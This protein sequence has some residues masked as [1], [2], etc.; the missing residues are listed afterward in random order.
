MTSTARVISASAG[1]LCAAAPLLAHYPVMRLDQIR[2]KADLIFI[3]QVD[4]QQVRWWNGEKMQFTD[5]TFTGVEVLYAAPGVQ[6]PADG[7]IR[8]T[9]AGGNQIR[10]CCVPQFTAGDRLLI[11][12]HYDGKTYASAVVGG[13]QGAF[14]IERDAVT[15]AEHVLTFSGAAI[16]GFADG[17][18]VLSRKP[19]RIA[20][21]SGEYAE[22]HSGRLDSAPVALHTA[23]GGEVADAQTRRLAEERMAKP[24]MKLQ[25][26]T[27]LLVEGDTVEAGPLQTHPGHRH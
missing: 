19:Q 18:P 20:N 17:L 6:T 12:A 5:V 26:L 7:T 11:A 23:R 3:G 22:R 13:T 4:D 10:V 24:V 8:L 2:A 14:R 1:L 15:G 27:V 16:V 25:E 21:G 9:F